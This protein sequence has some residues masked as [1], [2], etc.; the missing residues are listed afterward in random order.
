[1]FRTLGAFVDGFDLDAVAAVAE[2]SRQ[3]ATA[4]PP[5]RTH[6]SQSGTYASGHLRQIVPRR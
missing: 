6:Q 2:V 4:Q 3:T 5:R 1:V